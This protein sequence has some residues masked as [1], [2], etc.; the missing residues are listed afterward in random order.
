MDEPTTK[1]ENYEG[2][3]VAVGNENTMYNG[4]RTSVNGL[5]SCCLLIGVMNIGDCR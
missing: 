4:E 1:D 3:R 5:L 2:W